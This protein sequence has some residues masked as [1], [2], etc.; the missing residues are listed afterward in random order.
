VILPMV[1]VREGT[2]SGEDSLNLPQHFKVDNAIIVRQ[3]SSLV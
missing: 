3:I 1:G 2:Q